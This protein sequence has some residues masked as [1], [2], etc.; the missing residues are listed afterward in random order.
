LLF[1]LKYAYTTVGT[2]FSVYFY[3]LLLISTGISIGLFF[4][5]TSISR[6]ILL[7]LRFFFIFL[8]CYPLKSYLEIYL[9]LMIP[10]VME[11][12]FYLD[13]PGSIIMQAVFIAGFLF[14][15]KKGKAWGIE[16]VPAQ[17]TTRIASAFVL[18]IAGILS[19]F[20]RTGGRK[21][22]LLIRKIQH[23]DSAISQLSNANIGFQSYVKTLEFQILMNERKRVSREIHDTVG[24][25]LTNIIMMMEEAVRLPDEDKDKRNDLLTLVRSQAQKGLEETRAALRQLRNEKI[26]QL[27]G[28]GMIEEMVE[29]FRKATGVDISVEYGNF[30][31]FTNKEI[32]AIIFRIIQEGMTNAIRHGMA[33]KIRISFWVT[34]SSLSVTIHDNG[35][36]AEQI[37][38]GIGIAGMKERL[39]SINGVLTIQ[40]APD[41]FKVTALI[42]YKENDGKNQNPSC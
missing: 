33:S 4:F 25:A 41:G 39:E 34:G 19:Q 20:I 17:L 9:L 26:V 11:V 38:E 40:K 37:V 21:N 6:F 29:S 13:I 18:V 36:G 35:I 7:I 28:T 15:Q 42:P 23:L 8:L 31:D 32:Y 12:S 10:L 3:I 2:L 16:I 30:N 14:V 1:Y 27:E 5:H 22:K 24:Y